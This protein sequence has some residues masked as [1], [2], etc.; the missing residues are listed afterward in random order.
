MTRSGAYI[1][2]TSPRSGSTL[3]CS[4]LR[5]TGAAGHPDSWFHD[6]SLQGWAANLGVAPGAATGRA[7]FLSLIEAATRHGCAGGSLFALRLQ[8]QSAPFFLETLRTLHPDAASDTARLQRCFGP[9][10]FIHLTRRDK[11]EQAISHEIARQ[12]GLWHRAAD[13]SELERLAPD[14]TPAYDRAALEAQ[15]R[16]FAAHDRDWCAWFDREGIAPLRLSYDDLADDP[17]AT[18]RRV[19][20]HLGLDADLAHG[21][22]PGVRKLADATNRIWKERYLKDSAPG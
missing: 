20:A 5:A 10:R 14:R 3:L 21:V 15:I 9:T 16:T 13:G 11:I 12:S 2:C 22:R 6:P 8:R 7:L 19:L 4:L 17:D 18:L 1:I